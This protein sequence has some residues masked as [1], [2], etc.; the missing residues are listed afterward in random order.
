MLRIFKVVD[1]L[2]ILFL[3]F[4][5]VII[6]RILG[7]FGWDLLLNKCLIVVSFCLSRFGLVSGDINVWF[8]VV[9]SDCCEVYWFRDIVVWG[10][11]L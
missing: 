2:M 7:V 11:L 9:L 10:C 1:G 4:L 3:D 8:I 6:I 5:L